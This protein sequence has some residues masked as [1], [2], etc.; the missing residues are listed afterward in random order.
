MKNIL[1]LII[2]TAIFSMTSI[3]S[4]AQYYWDDDKANEEQSVMIEV[5]GKDGDLGKCY[6]FNI[7]ANTYGEF[8]GKI[9]DKLEREGYNCMGQP[10][11][12]DVYQGSFGIKVEKIDFTDW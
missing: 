11:C 12:K 9:V 2:F 4:Y 10:W 6:S 3:S 7:T 8:C 1:K 5:E